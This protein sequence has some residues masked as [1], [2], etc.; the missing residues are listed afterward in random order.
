MKRN[1]YDVMGERA[2]LQIVAALL[3]AVLFC[4]LNGCRPTVQEST[5]TNAIGP[6]SDKQA[7]T[8]DPITAAIVQDK[9]VGC[10]LAANPAKSVVLEFDAA[11]LTPAELL[12]WAVD[13]KRRWAGVTV[14]TQSE[15]NALL[16]YGADIP[17]PTPPEAVQFSTIA[18]A[19][20]WPGVLIEDGL[21]PGTEG[22]WYQ[23]GDFVAV[24]NDRKVPIGGVQVQPNAYWFFNMQDQRQHNFDIQGEI[25]HAGF[26]GVVFGVTELLPGDRHNRTYFEFRVNSDKWFI[27]RRDGSDETEVYARDWWLPINGQTT[28]VSKSKPLAYRITTS[29]NGNGTTLLTVSAA[30]EGAVVADWAGVVSRDIVGKVGAA[31]YAWGA[32][33]ARVSITYTADVVPQNTGVP[34]W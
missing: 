26:T 7:G 6:G 19:V 13:I 14:L 11:P 22:G 15:R 30:Y 33:T 4:F 3:V 17:D 12:V 31:D 28:I 23:S 8:F 2:A 25:Y 9:C 32:T 21:T 34:E 24:V 29:D 27:R 20:S 1:E 16:A 10:H 18:G 5:I